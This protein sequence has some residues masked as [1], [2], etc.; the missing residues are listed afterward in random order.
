MEQAAEG[1]ES[2]IDLKSGLMEAPQDVGRVEGGGRGGRRSR[3]GVEGAG[4]SGRRRWDVVGG[5]AG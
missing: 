4:C 1:L 3:S 2:R 5:L